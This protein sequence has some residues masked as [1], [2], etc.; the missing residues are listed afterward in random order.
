MSESENPA[1]PSPT[2]APNR[3]RSNQDWWPN[4]L[5]L[6]VLHQHSAKSDPMGDD[7][8]YAEEFTTLDVEAL[9]R[10]VVELMTTSQ[11]IARKMYEDSAKAGQTLSWRPTVSLRDGLARTLASVAAA[12]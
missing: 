3:P 8:D 5:D 2:P 6:Q 1:V 7:Y 11:E 12:A 4:Q 10:D 9:K